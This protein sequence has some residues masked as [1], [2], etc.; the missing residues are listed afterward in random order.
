[1]NIFLFILGLIIAL[2]TIPAVC[3]GGV[4][5]GN[6][7]YNNEYKAIGLAYGVGMPVG[8]ILLVGSI[9]LTVWEAQIIFNI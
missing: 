2:G 7:F 5:C 6:H 8:F 4:F 3:L 1:M 9:S